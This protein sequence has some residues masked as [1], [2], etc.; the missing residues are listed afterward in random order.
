MTL[1][2]TVTSGTS[3]EYSAFLVAQ[4]E[5]A[6]TGD[7]VLLYGQSDL[8]E[9]N[10]TFE[11]QQYLPDWV[12]I[13]DDGGG[14]AI[15]MRLDGSP[16]VYRCGHGAIGSLDPELVSNSFAAWLADDCPA[17]WMDDDDD[18]GDD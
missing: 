3:P 17:R 18:Y 7:F 11:V 16:S 14:T 10:E 9:R 1:L 5:S 15:L 8:S 13:G 2:E 12:A 6:P 4:P